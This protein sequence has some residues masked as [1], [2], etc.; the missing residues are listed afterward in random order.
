MI[1]TTYIFTLVI[2]YF[3]TTSVI[4]SRTILNH[5]DEFFGFSTNKTN[6]ANMQAHRVGQCSLKK[7]TTSNS[8]S[9]EA[10]AILAGVKVFACTPDVMFIGASKTGTSSMAEYI[11]SHPMIRNVNHR[12]KKECSNEAHLF[13][14]I[15]S[16]DEIIEYILKK[17]PGIYESNLTHRHLV[18]E[19]TPNYLL[20]DNI[21]RKIMKTYPLVYKKIKFIILLRNPS[22]RAISSF[23][24]KTDKHRNFPKFDIC[25]QRGFDQGRCV[26]D[27]YN[28]GWFNKSNNKE[29]NIKYCRE[30]HDE[31]KGL[32]G[33]KSTLAH[34]VKSMYYYQLLNWFSI[35]DRSQFFI[36]TIEQY[37]QN[38]MYVYEQVL[39]FLGL[40]LHDP[41][42]RFGFRDRAEV[43]DLLRI[44]KNVTP[45]NEKL[46]SQ[47]TPEVVKALDKFYA[48]HNILLKQLLGWDPGY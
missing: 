33:G 27:C 30:K 18:L 34:I 19:Y 44:R 48:P 25:M 4:A 42:G 43:V 41:T 21:P 39:N 36:F 7:S 8:N 29:C 23:K 13:D 14:K 3:L 5:T 6:I 10:L 16:S 32:C 26:M 15:D 1:R 35:F 17:Q 45:P 9:S 28:A 22:A 11:Q 40:P 46:D 37:S 20:D 24:A 31:K 38:P 2:V 12:C 47:I